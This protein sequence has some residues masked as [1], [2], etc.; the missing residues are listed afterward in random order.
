MRQVEKISSKNNEPKNGSQ[1]QDT[2]SVETQASI[3]TEHLQESAPDTAGIFRHKVKPRTLLVF[4]IQ[5]PPNLKSEIAAD[6]QPRRDYNE[7][8]KAL[9]ADVIYANDAMAMPF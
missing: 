7:L 6:L 9:D 5:P 8:Q 3:Q 2:S 1:W 4:W